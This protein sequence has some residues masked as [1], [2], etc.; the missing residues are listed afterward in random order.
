[1]LQTTTK[2]QQC[3]KGDCMPNYLIQ[4][5]EEGGLEGSKVV[6]GD[7]FDVEDCGI[8]VHKEGKPVFAVSD[9]V[10]VVDVDEIEAIETATAAFYAE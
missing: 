6:T 8:V 10:V 5:N 4:I 1:M 7:Y 3:N 2:L 9:Y